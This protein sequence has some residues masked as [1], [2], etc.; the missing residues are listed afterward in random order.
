MS[1]SEMSGDGSGLPRIRFMD[2]T[3]T[4]PLWTADGGMSRG[5]ACEELGLD[6]AFVEAL[7]AWAR[8]GDLI[9]D[10][11]DGW[12][13]WLARGDWLYEELRERLEP[14]FEVVYVRPR[15]S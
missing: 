5:G 10:P 11:P 13:G 7:H 12:E 8:D 2:D 6:V 15:V 3:G 1:E 4:F 14:E 9:G